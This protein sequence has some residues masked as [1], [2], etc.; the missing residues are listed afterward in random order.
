MKV[1][2]TQSSP[3]L[4]D[5]KD[6]SPPGSSVHG[7]LQA[8]IVEWVIIP[9]SRGFS[10]PRDQSQVSHIAGR[11]FTIWVTQEAR[12]IFPSIRQYSIKQNGTQ[13]PIGGIKLLE[14]HKL[15]LFIY[16]LGKACLLFRKNL[17]R[18]NIGCWE[19]LFYK[20]LCNRCLLCYPNFFPFFLFPNNDQ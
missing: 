4:C 8:R 16:L 10:Q 20:R 5:P 19:M 1:L 3:T 7:I 12:G 15:V 9:L 18:T 13:E 6:C 14:N 17:M 2:V 11:F